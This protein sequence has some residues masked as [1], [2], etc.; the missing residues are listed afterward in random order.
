MTK[1]K[2]FLLLVLFVA[3]A[4]FTM[5]NWH[6]PEPPIKFLGL[7]F[8]PLPHGLIVICT[9]LLGFVVGW[10]VCALRMR[11]QP[12][13]EEKIE[14]PPKPHQEEQSPPSFSL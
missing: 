9:F 14:E 5:E 8:M 10:T 2:G 4:I 12:K 13:Q 3:L 11:M 6:F 7:R 1:V